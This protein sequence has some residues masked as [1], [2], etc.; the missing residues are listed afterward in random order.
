M[1]AAEVTMPQPLPYRGTP[2]ELLR[3][4]AP[5]PVS[6][7]VKLM[8]AGAVVAAVFTIWV[9]ILLSHLRTV[10]HSVTASQ[11]GQGEKSWISYGIFSIGLWLWMAW[12]TARGKSWAR[13][14]ST[15]IFG[16]GTLVTLGFV[17]SFRSI[18]VILPIL[19]FLAGLG[20]VIL[21]WRPDSSAFFKPP[22]G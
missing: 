8:F 6:N 22:Q 16:L 11:L 3:P 5:A 9:L 17:A 1:F 13:I 21:L 10:D 18:L 12:A 19:E 4:P 2:G 14:A 7:A 20:A 15:V